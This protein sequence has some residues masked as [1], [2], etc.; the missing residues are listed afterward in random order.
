MMTS[1]TPGPTADQPGSPD[2]PALQARAGE[3][4][5]RKRSVPVV[6]WVLTAILALRGLLSFVGALIFAFPAGGA[7]GIGLGTFLVATAAAY[8]YVAWRMR[9]G[10]RWVWLAALTV[11]IV[12]QGVLAVVDLSLSGTIPPED[13]L[14]IGVTVVT[15][16]LLFLPPVRKFFSR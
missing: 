6:V 16:L 9:F 4:G 3:T 1:H 15:V 12:N 14:F 11:P 13:Y 7:L 2:E 5:G 10:E 8:L